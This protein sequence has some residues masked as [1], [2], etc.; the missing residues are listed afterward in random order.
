MIYNTATAAKALG[1]AETTVRKRCVKLGWQRSCRDWQ[2]TE[3]QVAELRRVVRD[4]P[5]R[6][7]EY[8]KIRRHGIDANRRHVL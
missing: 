3:E 6:P 1:C 4:G 5:G 8:R 7:P 2:L